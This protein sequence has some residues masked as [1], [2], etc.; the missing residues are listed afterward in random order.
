M[1]LRSGAYYDARMELYQLLLALNPDNPLTIA[2]IDDNHASLRQPDDT[3]SAQIRR[4]T[5][6]ANLAKLERQCLVV[7]LD[8]KQAVGYFKR[9]YKLA[10][11]QGSLELVECERAIH[12]VRFAPE[13]A[14]PVALHF[15]GKA[16]DAYRAAQRTPGARQAAQVEPVVK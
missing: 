5:I 13:H 15:L 11:I 16:L 7:Q 3:S 10:T 14:K 4:R 6:A 9:A 8:L 2:Q 1:T 12:V